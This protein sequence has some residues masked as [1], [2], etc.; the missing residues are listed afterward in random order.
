MSEKQARLQR[1]QERQ[2]QSLEASI[3]FNRDEQGGVHASGN[4]ANPIASLDIIGKGCLALSQFY[5][6]QVQESSR[7]LRPDPMTVASLVRGN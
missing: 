3:T 1:Q 4:I 2:Q 5:A 7:I 6:Q